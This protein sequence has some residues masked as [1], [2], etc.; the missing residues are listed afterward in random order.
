VHSRNISINT[1]EEMTEML[2]GILFYLNISRQEIINEEYGNLS[3]E[4]ISS[5][6]DAILLAKALVYM[7][8]S[9][10]LVEG[11]TYDLNKWF[12]DNRDFLISFVK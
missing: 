10:S 9:E 4:S 7:C 1:S 6:D 3:N 5:I 2:N 12:E 11:A 8:L